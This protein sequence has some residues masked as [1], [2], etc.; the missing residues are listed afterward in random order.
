L[1]LYAKGGDKADSFV[2]G[3]YSRRLRVEFDFEVDGGIRKDAKEAAGNV[4]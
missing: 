3:K 1:R 4:I 2:R